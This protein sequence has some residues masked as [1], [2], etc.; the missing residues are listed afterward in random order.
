MASLLPA[1]T[2]TDRRILRPR[3]QTTP[4]TVLRISDPHHPCSRLRP[5]CG[6]A[7]P[8]Q[9][10]CCP[11]CQQWPAKSLAGRAM[12]RASC[13]EK[14]TSPSWR[15][16]HR[17]H[18]HT[19]LL[20]RACQFRFS[21]SRTARAARIWCMSGPTTPLILRPTHQHPPKA[22]YRLRR[23]ETQAD[24]N[25]TPKL[26]RGRGRN[27]PQHHPPWLRLHHLQPTLLNG[28]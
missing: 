9:A 22:P 23:G 4:R 6:P 5:T 10:R 8:L 11:R 25:P 15:S 21:N 1:W 2:T 28:L 14:E 24:H 18:V 13:L 26:Q 19:M 17:N 27:R 20:S 12:T 3:H 7:R 16:C